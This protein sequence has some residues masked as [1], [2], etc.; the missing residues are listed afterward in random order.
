M[1]IS[2]ITVSF[3]NEQTIADTIQSIK[4]QDHRN[5]EYIIIDGASQDTTLQVIDSFGPVVSHVVSE[6]DRGIYDAMNKGIGI[7]SGDAIGFLNADDMYYDSKVLSDVDLLFKRT[8]SDV[9]YGDIEFV[10]PV[11]TNRVKRKWRA[12]E[13]KPGSFVRGWMPPHPAFFAKKSIFL[14]YGSFRLDLGSSAD[15]ELM[16][17]FLH[18]NKVPA[19][20]LS[21]MCVK[22][23]LGGASNANLGNR[24]LANSND[25]KSWVVNGIRPKWYTTILKPLRKISQFF[26]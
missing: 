6:P 25:K 2:V 16:L 9:V 20:Y 14:K 21:R 26:V 3:N 1:K 22:M 24:L 19:V 18:V 13:Y 17:R 4:E 7:A 10:D 23:R 12:G 8:N 15:Y 11:H 5:I